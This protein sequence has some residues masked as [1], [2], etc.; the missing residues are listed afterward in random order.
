MEPHDEP[1]TYWLQIWQQPHGQKM[2]EVSYIPAD[3][4]LKEQVA[5]LPD[6]KQ[7]KVPDK[8]QGKCFLP[9]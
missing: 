2:P 1:D 7:A 9:G 8:Y 4:V 6:I 5:V 3:S